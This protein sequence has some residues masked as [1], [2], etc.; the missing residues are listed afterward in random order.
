[1]VSKNLQL[2]LDHAIAQYFLLCSSWKDPFFLQHCHET[3]WFHKFYF[4]FFAY[5]VSMYF[6][7]LEVDNITSYPSTQE[8][9]AVLWLMP[10]FQT[11]Q[12]KMH[13]DWLHSRK[14]ISKCKYHIILSI[15]DFSKDISVIF[16][17]FLLVLLSSL[18]TEICC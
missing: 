13:H 17:L 9:L 10:H 8:Q 3:A 1:M 11:R 16:I 7:P 18:F 5:K 4:W 12:W 15:W 2:Y 6:V 14:F